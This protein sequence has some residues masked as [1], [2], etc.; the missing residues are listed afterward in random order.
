MLISPPGWPERW[1]T[2]AVFHQRMPSR[3]K[4]VVLAR[5][6]S[7]KREESV[8]TVDPQLFTVFGLVTLALSMKALALGAA[9]AATRGRRKQFLNAEDAAWLKGAHV[10]PDP[11]AVAR[12]GRA[13]PNALENLFLF[14]LFRALSLAS[15]APPL[16]CFAYRR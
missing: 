5:S 8:V 6:V 9:T 15:R 4:R 11:E 1:R 2:S 13:H 12:I 14:S 7:Q 3:A 16:A 10:D